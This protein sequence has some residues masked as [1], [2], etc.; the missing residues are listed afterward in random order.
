MTGWTR[1]DVRG[2]A[3]MAERSDG[4]SGASVPPLVNFGPHCE[5]AYRGRPNPS[6]R[7]KAANRVP[8]VLVM[9]REAV[10]DKNLCTMSQIHTS[11][12]N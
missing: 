5:P 2:G 10:L 11:R 4:A 12:R 3:V 9:L 8:A 1:G 6:S 7:A